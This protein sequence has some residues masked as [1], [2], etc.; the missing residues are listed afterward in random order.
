M[1]QPYEKPLLIS[2]PIAV[3]VLRAQ[4]QCCPSV[5]FYDFDTFGEGIPGCDLA[6]SCPQVV[7]A[8]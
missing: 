4:T 3:D 2:E 6:C 5:N 7:G 1:K 8:S